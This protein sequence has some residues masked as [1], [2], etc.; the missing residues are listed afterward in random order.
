[1]KMR[2]TLLLAIAFALFGNIR[3]QEYNLFETAD[4]DADGWLWF[5][6]QEKIDKYVSLF[7]ENDGVID[8]E[9]KVIQ[10]S[11]ANHG[12]YEE[13]VADPSITGFGDQAKTGGIKLAMSS[14]W[15]LSNSDGGSIYLRLPS[16]T[17][18]S[19]CFSS[20]DQMR[21]ELMAALS[22]DT[23]VEEYQSL[24]SFGWSPLAN[25][26]EYVWENIQD[27]TNTST[28]P[29]TI[30]SSSPIFVRIVNGRTAYLII[31]GIKAMTSTPTSVSQNISDNDITFDGMNIVLPN[32]SEL[33]VYD[34][35]GTL[36]ADEV[37]NSMNTGKLNSGIYI[38]KANGKTMK[39]N[40]R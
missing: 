16:C 10:M 27:I 25:S 7:N 34:L 14:G 38:V 13:T 2:I 18:L 12:D 17:H 26:G 29:S 8:P 4:V 23:F 36:V 35:T 5:D 21:P 15:S 24:K 22:E 3:A 19:I 32:E 28:T 11:A 6:S 39:I 30:K 33:K 1:M 37:T 31:H 9:G 20:D 40:V